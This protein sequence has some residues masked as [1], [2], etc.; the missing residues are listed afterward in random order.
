MI[1]D[2]DRLEE[3]V[4]ALRPLLARRIAETAEI[5][6]TPA[7]GDQLHVEVLLD[8]DALKGLGVQLVRPAG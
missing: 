5:L 3:L 8:P 6:V 7:L 2:A 1:V 4:A